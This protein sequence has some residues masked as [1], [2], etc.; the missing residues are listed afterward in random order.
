MLEAPDPQRGAPLYDFSSVAEAAG[1]N[2]PACGSGDA[3]PFYQAR[4]VPTHMVL[5]LRSRE[6]ALGCSKGEIELRFCHGCGFIWNAR[7]DPRLVYYE[8]DYEATQAY[9]PTFNAFHDRLARDLVERHGLQGKEVLEIGCGQ[10]EFLALV[11]RHGA[12]SGIGFDPVLRPEDS[13]HPEVKLVKDWYSEKYAHLRSDCIGSK[14]V[15]EHIP[16]IGRFL[17]TLR[18]TIGDRPEAVTFGMVP[19][20]IRILEE[21][22]FWDIYYE[23]CSF[24]TPGSLARAYRRAGFQVSDLRTEYDGQY[25]MIGA[26]PG[27]TVDAPLPNE[28]SVAEL[29][30]RVD[31]FAAKVEADC[32]QWRRWIGEQA[33]AGK[34]VVLWGGGSK[35]VTF[36]NTLG[37]EG[38]IELAVDINTKKRDTY[39]AGTGQRIVTPDALQSHPPDVVIVMNP[40]YREEIA[41]E[42]RAMGLTP[43]LV[44]ISPPPRRQS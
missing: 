39:L 33:A 43:E 34:R 12:K 32:A 40:I 18:A 25:L 19:E 20:M 30:E 9:S 35:A 21:R 26:H 11:C 10:G 5:L 4:R 42:L 23:H 3:R 44:M 38:E 24:F 16:D 2:C 22:A 7:F 15:M 14:M 31:A 6:A 37:I 41:T 1:E 8:D 36:L 29:S 27:Q 13:P 17:A 28:E